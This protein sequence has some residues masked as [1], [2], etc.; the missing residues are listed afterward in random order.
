MRT[1]ANLAYASGRLAVERIDHREKSKL[2]EIRI[3]GANLR[4]PMF[5]HQHHRVHVMHHIAAEPRMTRGEFRQ[6]ID[7][8][9]GRGE[10]GDILTAH[11]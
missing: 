6:H 3:G 10:Y 5:A 2:V 4:D 9:I 8:A 7:M 1:D 11:E